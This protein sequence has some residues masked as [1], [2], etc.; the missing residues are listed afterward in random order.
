MMLSIGIL[1]WLFVKKTIIFSIH[2]L[3]YSEQKLSIILKIFSTF[4][5][6]ENPP[7]N[8]LGWGKVK[9]IIFKPRII[10]YNYTKY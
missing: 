3:P 5:I 10:Y 2:N 7:K 6:K 4:F 1:S 9:H 8:C